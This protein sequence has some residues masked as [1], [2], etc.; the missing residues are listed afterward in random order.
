MNIKNQKGRY[1]KVDIDEQEECTRLPLSSHHNNPT[2]Q[3]KCN[4]FSKP[5]KW[6]PNNMHLPA[7][8]EPFRMQSLMEIGSI[9]K[10]LRYVYH[11]CEDWQFPEVSY[12]NENLDKQENK[13]FNKDN[14]RSLT[15]K[16][17]SLGN[18]V[19]FPWYHIVRHQH[20]GHSLYSL[21]R[22]LPQIL[23]KSHL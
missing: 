1:R 15:R 8:N 16:A 5:L 9:S 10:I 6:C 21:G 2:T 20:L 11:L 4:L 23:R 14:D 12:C 18:L 3:L 17:A 7:E 19:K 22:N 13:P